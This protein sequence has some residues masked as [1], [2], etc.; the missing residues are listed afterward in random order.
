MTH[1]RIYLDHNA[2]S[3]LRDEA[4]E[5]MLAAFALVGNA[6]SPHQ[7]GRQAR[8]MIDL[9]RDRIAELCGANPRDVVF[10]GGATEA[11]VLALSPSLTSQGLGGGEGQGCDTLLMLGTEHPCVLQGHRFPADRVVLLPVTPAGLIDLD[12]LD[13]ALEQHC[14]AGH[15]VMV[16]VQA[17]NSETGVIQPI[18]E[19]AMRVHAAGGLLHCDAVQMA[20]R[21][22]LDQG[23][24]G[25]D[26]LA[27]SA[28]KLGGPQGVGAL[29]L[30]SG[31]LTVDSPVLKGGG[32]ERGARAGTENVAGIA[33]FGAAAVAASRDM[34]DEAVRLACLRDRIETGLRH[35]DSGLVMFGAE[36]PRLPNTLAFAG[37]EHSAEMALMRLDLAGIALSSGSACS[38]GKVKSSHVLAA[39]G[40]D[41]TVARRALRI[42]LGWS[43]QE[44]EVIQFMTRYEQ[45]LGP[46]QT[47]K[48]SGAIRAA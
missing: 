30:R 42:S 45:T 39:M 15:R 44:D 36:A 27:L 3:P 11:N 48:Q 35:L 22:P 19:I 23:T 5:A 41:G 37:S 9:A 12:A 21:L 10:T 17:A 46:K 31:G 13:R 29:V 8:G 18:S 26:C 32:Q 40:V 6:S 1:K 16:S 7:E 24:A 43:T 28:H 34:A 25:A 47:A 4:R 14:A 33:G 20:G 2:T 38:S